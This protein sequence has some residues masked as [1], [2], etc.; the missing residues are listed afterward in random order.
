MLEAREA[1][2]SC[3]H[4][5]NLVSSAQETLFWL[6]PPKCGSSF[7]T[8]VDAYRI[9]PARSHE[10]HQTLPS[11]PETGTVGLFREPRERLLS[12]YDY[13]LG[14][15][16]DEAHRQARCCWDDWGWPVSVFADVHRRILAGEPPNTTVAPFIGCQANMLIGHG[17]MSRHVADASQTPSSSELLAKALDAVAQMRF[18]GLFAS[19][20]LSI[21]L[22]NAMMT[23]V[24]FVLPYQMVNTRPS[25]VRLLDR[26]A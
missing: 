1:Q 12:S 7:G 21:C 5:H 3:A 18:V 14:S 24:R 6:H 8:S 9:S 25:L 10:L 26:G 23:G 13:I 4:V 22:F 2:I 11:P 20:R 17:C 16:W 15:G 19:W